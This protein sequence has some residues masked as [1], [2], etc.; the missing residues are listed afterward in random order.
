MSADRPRDPQCARYSPLRK[1]SETVLPFPR[2][3]SISPPSPLVS[4]LFQLGFL[5]L[6]EALHGAGPSCSTATDHMQSRSSGTTL[7]RAQRC[8]EH[9]G[10]AGFW[11]GAGESVQQPMNIFFFLFFWRE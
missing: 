8:H 9:K 5:M 10:R 1:D 6:S 11:R 2:K 3:C 4:L 7:V